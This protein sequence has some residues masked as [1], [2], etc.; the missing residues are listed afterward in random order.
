MASE[1]KSREGR[2][3]PENLPSDKRN[4]SS[5]L[6]LPPFRS[7]RKRLALERYLT[8]A[9]TRFKTWR[10]ILPTEKER[11][12]GRLMTIAQNEDEPEKS[13]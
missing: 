1:L 5:G 13:G 4:P 11:L 10:W 9:R 2:T 6:A 12:S 7:E 3:I 8:S